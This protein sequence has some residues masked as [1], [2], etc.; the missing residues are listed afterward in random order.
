MAHSPN[1]N[2]P[3]IPLDAEHPGYPVRKHG[4]LYLGFL[5]L[6]GEGIYA[7]VKG[8]VMGDRLDLKIELMPDSSSKGKA[9]IFSKIENFQ[10]SPGHY[11]IPIK[12]GIL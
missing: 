6:E 12:S 11:V 1:N 7:R 2:L 3:L 8:D 9:N 10:V 4:V 5:S